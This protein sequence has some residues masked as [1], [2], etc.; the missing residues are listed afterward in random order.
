MNSSL[1]GVSCCLLTQTFPLFLPGCHSRHK[2]TLRETNQG[3]E[4]GR[5]KMRVWPVIHNQVIS[6][7]FG[8]AE[9][10]CDCDSLLGPNYQTNFLLN[11]GSSQ[12]RHLIKFS[13]CSHFLSRW[14][15]RGILQTQWEKYFK[16]QA[17]EKVF[18]LSCLLQ[19]KHENKI[20]FFFCPQMWRCRFHLSVI[21]P[22]FVWPSLAPE[23]RGSS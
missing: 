3:K 20:I 13:H 5:E 21:R 16:L 19:V 10:R 7:P 1:G 8:A 14:R 6:S 23:S 17:Y 12:P 15:E 11:G 18:F 22:G 2:I 9:Q 4:R